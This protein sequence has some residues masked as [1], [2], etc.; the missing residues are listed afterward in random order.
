MCG[1]LP[2]RNASSPTRFVRKREA[3]WNPSPSLGESDRS[4][5]KRI[6]SAV[7]GAFDGGE[8]RYVV[9]M[10]IVY[11]HTSPRW[12]ASGYLAAISGTGRAGSGPAQSG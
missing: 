2:E 4:I 8:K 5:V 11:V 3:G 9:R 10:G 6:D 7:T 12:T 1:A